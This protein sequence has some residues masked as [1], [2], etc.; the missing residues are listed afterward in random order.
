[1]SVLRNA[2]N[3]QYP[4]LPAGSN[5]ECRHSFVPDEGIALRLHNQR[6][7]GDDSDSISNCLVCQSTSSLLYCSGCKTVLYCGKACQLHHWK[8]GHKEACKRMI[9]LPKGGRDLSGI[10]GETK[11]S[12]VG[13]EGGFSGFIMVSR[14]RKGAR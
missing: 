9:E 6:L 12:D 1:M 4:P 13:L 5:L 14:Q 11:I 7:A 2:I 8:H 3:N 10:A